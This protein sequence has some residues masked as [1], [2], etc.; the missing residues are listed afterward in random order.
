MNYAKNILNMLNA[1]CNGLLCVVLLRQSLSF[2]SGV[3]LRNL[4]WSK[5]QT[6]LNL[7]CTL[8]WSDRQTAGISSTQ[9]PLRSVRCCSGSR[10]AETLLDF[11]FFSAWPCE[12]VVRRCQKS[13]WGRQRS[14]QRL[15]YLCPAVPLMLF[16]AGV[17]SL[18]VD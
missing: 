6:R 2:L 13:V 17:F 11:W 10:T 3:Y 16:V 1:L 5:K 8:F 14:Q 12:R 7:S 4:V 18:P 9:A 15:F